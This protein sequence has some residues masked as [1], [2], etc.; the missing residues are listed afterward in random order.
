VTGRAATKEKITTEP[1]RR[2][3]KKEEEETTAFE[4]DYMD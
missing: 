4:G 2:R 1:Q 3:G